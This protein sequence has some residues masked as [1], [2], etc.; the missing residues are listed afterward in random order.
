MSCIVQ[1]HPANDYGSTDTAA[2]NFSDSKRLSSSLGDLTESKN[3]LSAGIEVKLGTYIVTSRK[4]IKARAPPPP[5]PLI[6]TTS[7]PI[8]KQTSSSD[9]EESRVESPESKKENLLLRKVNLDICL[10]DGQERPVTVDGSKAVMD[11]LVDLCSQ[12]HLNPAHH[13][14]EIKPGTSHHSLTLRPNT[15]IGTLD[16]KT[17]CLKE[18]VPEVKVRKPPPRIPEKTVRLIVNFLGTQKTV[19][20]VNPTVPLRSILPVVCEK[21][22]FK[23]DP[24]ILLKDGI[25]KEE[26][27]MSKSLNDLGLK[28]LYVLNTKQEKGRSLSTSS[29]TTEKEKKGILGFFRSDKRSNKNDGNIQAMDNNAYEEIF[30]T[31]R[32]SGSIYKGF[33]TAPSSPSVNSRSVALGNSLS[34]SN[35]CETDAR[36]EVKKRR[37]PPPPKAATQEMCMVKIS[38]RKE[39]EQLY[40]SIQR[41]Q[42]KKKRRA[43]P[44]PTLQLPNDLN[45]KSENKKSTA[46][47]GRQVP[48]KPPRSNTRSPPQLI[49]PPPP[50]YPPPDIDIVDPHIFENGADVIESIKHVPVPAKREKTLIR[51]NSVSSE[52][53][54]IVDSA[55]VI[56]LQSVNNYVEYSEIANV[57][58][59][60]IFLDRQ[61]NGTKSRDEVIIKESA[62]ESGQNYTKLLQTVRTNSCDSEDLCQEASPI[63][64]EEEVKKVED[65]IT[66]QFQHTFAE[67]D[68]DSEDIDETD[69]ACSSHEGSW[70][71]REIDEYSNFQQKT[72]TDAALEVPVTIIDEV[73][74]DNM[75]NFKTTANNLKTSA[76]EHDMQQAATHSEGMDNSRKSVK[77]IHENTHSNI[78]SNSPGLGL[79]TN[80]SKQPENMIITS[81]M[82]RNNNN[83]SSVYSHKSNTENRGTKP[84][85]SSPLPLPRSETQQLKE[86]V[87]PLPQNKENKV[88]NVV[89]KM[90][91]QNQGSKTSESIKPPLWRQ[92]T[93]EP[94]VGMTTFTV[95]PPKPDVKKYDRGV[96]LSASAIKIDDL[97][98]LISPQSSFDK[99]DI[100]ISLNNETEG[101]LVEKAKEFWRSSSMDKQACETKEQSAK[102]L[103]SVK[104]NKLNH[105]DTEQK[106]NSPSSKGTPQAH[107][108]KLDGRVNGLHQTKIVQHTEQP[109]EKM[110]IIEN[111]SKARTDLPFLKPT[112]RISSQYVAS[113]AVKHNE[114][115]TLKLLEKAEAK[116]VTKSDDRKLSYS[117]NNT[118][119]VEETKHTQESNT[120]LKRVLSNNN[121]IV[122]GNNPTVESNISTT[123]NEQ[124]QINTRPNNF[125]SE[126]H[127]S[128]YI[129]GNKSTKELAQK[130]EKTNF[131]LQ[132]SKVR[133][134]TGSSS[135]AFLNAVREKSA[136]IEQDHIFVSNKQPVSVFITEKEDKANRILST[137]IDE[138]DSPSNSDLFGPK[139]KLRP[140]IQKAVP[141]DMSLHSAL[142]GAI[143]SGEG[144]EKLRKIQVSSAAA[145]EL[146]T[147]RDTEI[148][149]QN[150]EKAEMKLQ[151]IPPPPSMPPPPPATVVKSTPKASPILTNNDVDVRGA[152]LEAIRSGSGASRLKKVMV[153]PN[154]F[155]VLA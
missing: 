146:Q 85:V 30:K 153:Q 29:D 80:N 48:Q 88:K 108:S 99:K 110:I 4:K 83:D 25:S 21:C 68:E 31:K 39:S 36:P 84:L 95:V 59:D 135:N 14:L 13:I 98:N 143:Q 152:L 128:Q 32:T 20:R 117:R 43:P 40:V 54:L 77:T 44:P 3:K 149:S 111:T 6:S 72:E 62:I 105:H 125:S 139:A 42:H 138:P 82:H 74:D 63:K 49:I 16:V 18:K 53:V 141:K 27:D 45:E 73:P 41:D 94:K 130:H 33:S 67:L 155:L 137:V 114:P 116:Q 26:L 12:Y 50:S 47:N 79:H 115:S 89:E 97:G 144:K 11:L 56:H 51:C 140:V 69:T 5:A 127:G 90:S 121:I 118:F 28:E 22:E 91:L 103:I 136:K 102:K 75:Y 8:M 71:S 1:W 101:P 46:G 148:C 60:N 15:H 96:S 61:R 58:S 55:D 64:K 70:S 104:T 65:F 100:Y 147:L 134:T 76:R 57:S 17:L 37:A 78:A 113:A 81:A 129:V 23:H 150:E 66:S 123:G 9:S 92:Q 52:E 131:L 86:S 34:L 109:Q 106:I 126:H 154:N 145:D 19:V 2:P 7:K 142:M 120:E 93:F 122:K 151:S 87:E 35:I 119:S 107:N 112:K 10:P 38:E 133:V 124:R 132:E 24:V